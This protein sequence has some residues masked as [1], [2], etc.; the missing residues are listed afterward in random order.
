[1]AQDIRADETR[2]HNNK[3][4]EAKKQGPKHQKPYGQLRRMDNEW[5]DK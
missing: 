3:K 5:M 4:L 2:Q 1:M